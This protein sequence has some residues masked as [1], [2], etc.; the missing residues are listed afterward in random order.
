MSSKVDPPRSQ[1]PKVSVIMPTYNRA[2]LLPAAVGSVLAQTFSDFELLIVDDGSQDHTRQVVAGFDDLRI[3]YFHQKNSGVSAARN[4]GLEIARGQYLAFLDSDDLFLPDKL[5]VQVQQLDENPALGMVAG[6]FQY[7]DW[8]GRPLAERRP[9][10]FQPA[11]GLTTVL[12]GAAIL[13]NSV[14][15]R[16]NWIERVGNFNPAFSW[17]E[18]LDL[19]LRLVVA[20][21]AMGWTQ[22]VVCAYRMHAEQAVRDVSRQS[23]GT[24]DVFEALYQRSDL[25]EPALRLRSQAQAAARVSVAGR[26]Y[27]AKRYAASRD[28]LADALR[29]DPSLAQGD[30][31][32]LL[33]TLIAWGAEP[34]TGDPAEYALGLL[35]NLPNGVD[36]AE[37]HGARIL[38]STCISAAL[39]AVWVKRLDLASA[40]L[41]NSYKITPSTWQD[42][43]QV[44]SV[45][46]DALNNFE[47]DQRPA[48]MEQWFETLPPQLA[49]VQTLRKKAAGRLFMAHGFK[50]QQRGHLDEAAAAF[51]QGIRRDPAWLLNRGVLAVLARDTLKLTR[52]SK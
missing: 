1:R 8:Q 39:D 2:D 35:K 50:A 47:A 17:A 44:V 11:L 6:G 34:V 36:W 5:A 33:S 29:L 52:K 43:S 22:A 49:G 37:R 15:L 3:H 20:G 24:L 51:R 9:W 41:L 4:R 13:T 12:L 10:T 21:C 14:L 30:K 25:P 16:A 27:G 26:E 38:L 19:W 31:P 23:A 40:Y 7:I 18:D 32:P 48:L 46:T 28:L 45:L 42:A